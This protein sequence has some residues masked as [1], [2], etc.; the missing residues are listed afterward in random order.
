MHSAKEFKQHAMFVSA[1]E[2]LVLVQQQAAFMERY[3]NDFLRHY[4]PDVQPQL[5][6]ALCAHRRSL[7]Q[8]QELCEVMDTVWLESSRTS[9]DESVLRLNSYIYYIGVLLVTAFG[10]WC[11]SMN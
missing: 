6:A 7:L 8:L 5:W 1:Q 3:I 9:L 11:V 4:T 2:E 10:M